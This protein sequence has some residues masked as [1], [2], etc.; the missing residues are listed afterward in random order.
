[1]MASR[2]LEDPT[3]LFHWVMAVQFAVFVIPAVI[4]WIWVDRK[5]AWEFR[6][7]VQAGEERALVKPAGG[8]RAA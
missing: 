8:E 1:M 4:S 5:K 7:P 3:A 6:P 2:P